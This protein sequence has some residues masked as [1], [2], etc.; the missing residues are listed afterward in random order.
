VHITTGGGSRQDFAV[1][2]IAAHRL[3]AAGFVEV[4]AP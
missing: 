1:R 2:L 3:A 4:A